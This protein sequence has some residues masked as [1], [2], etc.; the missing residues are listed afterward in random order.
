VIPQDS[1]TIVAPIAPEKKDALLDL[2]ATMNKLPG[3][4]DPA[5][6][7]VPFGDFAGL[8]FARF[9]VLD[10]DTLSDLAYYGRSFPNAPVYLVFLG[11]CDGPADRL[12]GE[13]AQGAEAGLR[14]IFAHCCDYEPAAPLLRWMKRHA[15]RPAA[16]YVNFVGRTVRQIRYDAALHSE[17]I[18]Y[19][20]EA[21]G[22]EGPRATH[23]RL[24]RAVRERGPASEPEEPGAPLWAFKQWLGYAV[25]GF[26]LVAGGACLVTTPLALLIPLFLFRLRQ[27]ERSDP[28]IVPRPADDR[29]QAL[30]ALEDHDVTNQFSAFGSVKPGAFRA[31]TVTALLFFLNFVNR[32]LYSRGHLA[33]IGT[34]HFARWVVLDNKRRIFFASNYD[35][36]LETY[37]DD[38]VNK[39]A[40]GINL[41]FSN[42][43][44][45]PRTRFL[46][47]DGAKNERNYQHFLRRHQVPTQV[48]YNAYPGLT[49]FDINR[50]AL[51]REGLAR[52]PTSD[53]E[54]RKWLALI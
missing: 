49:A 43:V 9:V 4:A 47:L 20:G 46:I 13:L 30:A 48:W 29:V 53:A 35:R 37:A 45:F 41:V 2:L 23:E 24:T 8:H 54:I 11:D 32:A 19:L 44:G 27:L 6:E 21:P 25:S 33:R 51:I 16:S 5:N 50:N 34:I 18:K 12:L 28:V 38:F 17:L 36:S 10:D 31:A 39:V 7:L 3:T 52:K 14:R 26:V 22:P 40:Y 42:G 1:F 15:V